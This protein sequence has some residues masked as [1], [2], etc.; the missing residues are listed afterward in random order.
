MAAGAAARVA[1]GVACIE[2]AGGVVEAA[3]AMTTGTARL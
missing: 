2:A 3:V 1:A